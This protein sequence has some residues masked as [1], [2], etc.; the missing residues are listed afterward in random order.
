M[1]RYILELGFIRLLVAVPS[2]GQTAVRVGA[3]PNITHA[4]AMVGKAN[5]SFEKALGSAARIRWTSFNAG[6][7]AIEAPSTL[8]R[9]GAGHCLRQM[10]IPG[11]DFY[12]SL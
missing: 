12:E 5:G 10:M 9:Y 1:K 3:F 11:G 7:S 6:R 2:Q 8:R 4:Q